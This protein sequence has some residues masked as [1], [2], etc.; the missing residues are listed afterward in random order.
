MKIRLLVVFLWLLAPA[1]AEEAVKAP[2][3]TSGF[4]EA[5]LS[6]LKSALKKELAASLARHKQQL[7]LEDNRS[8]FTKNRDLILT[9]SFTTD[10]GLGEYA[11]HPNNGWGREFIQH[12][13]SL[14]GPQVWIDVG[15]G[16]ANAQID[17]LYDC[18][19]ASSSRFVS[20]KK[21]PARLIALSVRKPE[22]APR[23]KEALWKWPDSFQYLEMQIEIFP[24]ST[25]I[26]DIITDS[27]GAA[28]YSPRLDLILKKYG[29]I[30]KKGGRV[31]ISGLQSTRIFNSRREIELVEWFN[32]IQGFKLLNYKDGSF[33]LEKISDEIDIP[34]LEIVTFE[35]DR[36]P[37]RGY[38]WRKSSASGI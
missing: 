35:A 7:N 27:W 29:R 31:Y 18:L 21:D 32:A 19:G 25:P 2:L 9:N 34:A 17:Y 14:R 13:S 4:N 10:R 24:D 38:R 37:R 15:A 3:S 5:V 8:E 23:L 11:Y 28:A 33:Q 6:E 12:L 22:Y 26:A 20:K 16:E 1:G 36:P 30:L